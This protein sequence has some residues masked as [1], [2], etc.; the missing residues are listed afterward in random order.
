ALDVVKLAQSY[1]LRAI[2]LKNHYEPTTAQAYLMRKL[3]PGIEVF[4]GMTLDLTNGG[5]NPVAVEH[6]AKMTGGYGKLLWFPTYDSEASVRNSTN[7]RPF[8]Q[9]SRDGALTTESKEVISIVKK[10]GLALAKGHVSPEEGM[11]LIRDAHA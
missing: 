11:M 5:V 10:Y 6:M 4:G 8:A 7:K 1:G 2:V 9:V 3:F